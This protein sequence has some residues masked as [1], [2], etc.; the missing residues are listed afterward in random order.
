MHKNAYYTMAI[1][2]LGLS[3]CTTESTRSTV[4]PAA[5]VGVQPEISDGDREFIREVG[6]MSIGEAT[7]SQMAL[8][9]SQTPAVRKLA[10]SIIN[11]HAKTDPELLRITRGMGY[12]PP[13]DLDSGRQGFMDK[14]DAASGPEFDKIYVSGQQMDHEQSLKLFRQEAMKGKA[15]RSCVPLPPT[16]Y[17]PW[18]RSTRR[19]DRWPARWGRQSLEA[20][21]RMPLGR[22]GLTG[23]RARRGESAGT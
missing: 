23:G 4:T 15:T 7:S 3:A 20:F 2:A 10:Q 1:L 9:R 14:L 17:L 8:E 18:S 6:R 11:Y 5:E 22:L 19:S 12:E 21:R 13:S 16:I